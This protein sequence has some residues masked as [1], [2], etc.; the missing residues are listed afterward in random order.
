M[1]KKKNT[2]IKFLKSFKYAFNGIIMALKS[3]FNLRFHFI[4]TIFV[5]ILGFLCK[6]DKYE[7]FICLILIGIVISSELFNTAIEKTIDIISPEYNKK[8]KFVKDVSSGAVL[9]L[10]FISFLIGLIIF[11]PKMINI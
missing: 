6:I 10:A 8:A 5:I 3:E 4:A 11:I 9:I 7:W 2:L 1:K